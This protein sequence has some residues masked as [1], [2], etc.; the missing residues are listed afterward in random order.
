[1]LIALLVATEV[2]ASGVNLREVAYG[3][4][5]RDWAACHDAPLRRR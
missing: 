5:L 2:L 3:D 1:M 4:L